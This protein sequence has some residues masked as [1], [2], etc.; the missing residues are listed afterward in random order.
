[1]SRLSFP[2]LVRFL[3]TP[4]VRGAALIMGAMTAMV[5]T[6][7]WV[8]SGNLATIRAA[9]DRLQR[10]AQVEIVTANVLTDALDQET[11]MRGFAESGTRAYL[12]PFVE[13]QIAFADDIGKLEEMT[14]DNPTEQ[15][16]VQRVRDAMAH[17]RRVYA[18]P[19]LIRPAGQRSD[20]AL[21]S[22]G[23]AAM[24]DVRQAIS[25]VRAGERVLADAR[26]AERERAI[27][28]AY[29]TLFL[30]GG[31]VLAIGLGL[32][33]RAM[34]LI[35]RGEQQARA[36]AGSMTRMLATVSHEIRTPLNGMLG[37]LQAMETERL[38][39]AQ[40]ERVGLA[41]ESGQILTVLLNDLL[42]ASKIGAG[43]MELVQAGFEPGE[44]LRRIE[45]VFAPV[46]E[47]KDVS[48]RFDVAPEVAGLWLGD[49]IRLGQI[50]T[51]LVSNAVKFTSAGKVVVAV[52]APRPDVLSVSV[53]DS[54]IGMDAA[55]LAGLFSPFTQADAETA[56]RFGG[57]GLGLSIARSLARLMG[58]D[59]TVTSTP[60]QGSAF[61]VTTPL[62][63]A[64]P[65]SAAV[66]VGPVDLAGLRVL[67]ADDN[68]MNRRV[69]AAI[70]PP[71]GI[72]LTLVEDG[73]A[74]VARWAP[75]AFDRVLLDLRMPGC[76]G[77]EVARRIR[78]REGSGPLT[79][80]ILLSGDASPEIQ[81]EATRLG[82]A[83]CVPKPIEIPVLLAALQATADTP[84]RQA[85]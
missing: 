49:K 22:A 63:R 68:A 12:D 45:A 13:G 10:S 83:A 82:F 18:D 51:N 53:R 7:V 78:A 37:M 16:Q 30:A 54:G 59:I 44:V 6:L 75:G 79:P 56:H 69:L 2:S 74:A 11:G 73:E 84:D 85:A 58:G 39:P 77:F 31:G 52:T 35:S 43:R 27:A 17:W 28:T 72:A 62:A 20:P 14:R 42:D 81:T 5:V 38:A 40:R 41:R 50:W 23:K 32:G 15:A 26:A 71:L 48:L 3:Q 21:Q 33:A 80:L 64:E 34:V 1:M 55:A 8:V 76:D 65:S 25:D 67:A 66:A 29:L 57:T 19:V 47:A 60:G 46:A 24:D 36:H 9:G 61:T 4:T 70:L